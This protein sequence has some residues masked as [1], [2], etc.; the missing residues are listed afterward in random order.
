MFLLNNKFLFI[1][2]LFFADPCNYFKQMQE[3]HNIIV[4]TNLI[5]SSRKSALGIV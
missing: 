3:N 4:N 2:N 1:T 5:F